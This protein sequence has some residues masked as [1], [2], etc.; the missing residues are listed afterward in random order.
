[1]STANG[2][3]GSCKQGIELNVDC[4]GSFYI[5][6]LINKV[7]VMALVDTGSAISVLHP[8]ILGRS[9]GG[10]DVDMVG[11]PDHI[12]LADGSLVSALGAATVTIETGNGEVT[13]EHC[14]VVA[15]VESPA[16]IGI[17][18]LRAHQCTLDVKTNTLSFGDKVQ[19]GW[20]QCGFILGNECGPV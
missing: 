5:P 6:L 8:T 4:L 10:R 14:M 19:C 11:G 7:P 20:V 3:T 12:K 1:M 17:Y 16:I 15:A 18:F 13:L 9:L 2:S